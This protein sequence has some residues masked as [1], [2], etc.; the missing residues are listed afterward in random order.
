MKKS[1]P[2]SYATNAWLDTL[3]ETAEKTWAAIQDS[4]ENPDAEQFRSTFNEIKPKYSTGF[5]DVFFLFLESGI[6]RWSTSTYRKVRTIFKHLREFEN[7][8]D[9][10]LSFRN[11]NDSFPGRFEDFYAEKGNNDA[12]TYKAVNIIVWF[13]NWATENGYNANLEYRRFYKSL[14]QPVGTPQAHHYLQ[15]EELLRLT[16]H[17]CGN[18]NMERVRDLFCFMC[19][20]GLRFSELQNLK[21]QDV[22]QKEVIIRKP[23]GKVR[24]IPLNGR[25]NQ[26]HDKYANK[27]YLNNT[28]FPSMSIITMNKYLKILGCEAGLVRQVPPARGTGEKVPFYECLTAGVAIHTFISNAIELEIPAEVISSFTG[29]RKDSRIGRIR[30]ELA[31]QE[32]RKLDSR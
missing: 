14:K 31:R 13:L 1:F 24:R 28:A 23:N 25:S 9:L 15:W 7:R 32:I 8:A 11:F 29:V 4:R 2:G 19:F 21:K 17:Q 5:F 27:Y 26:I 18:R 30:M 6:N 20:T 10:T 12:T 22:G 3:A 16:D